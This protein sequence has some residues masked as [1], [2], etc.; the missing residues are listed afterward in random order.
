MLN[1]YVLGEY[2]EKNSVPFF[3]FQ[4]RLFKTFKDPVVAQ[5]KGK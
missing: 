5:Q 4:R 2:K 1:K 3:N